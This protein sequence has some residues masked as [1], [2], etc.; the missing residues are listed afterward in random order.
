MKPWV[1]FR[2]I[3]RKGFSEQVDSII[4][5]QEEGKKAAIANL[6]PGSQVKVID[7]KSEKPELADITEHL[8]KLY[9]CESEAEMK[10]V[11]K[12]LKAFNL[13]GEQQSQLREAYDERKAQ[14]QA[15]AQQAEVQY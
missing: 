4:L 3:F 5:L 6:Y 8:E 11:A 15:M 2:P 7:V 9:L 13:T 14:L 1:L 12:S 10:S